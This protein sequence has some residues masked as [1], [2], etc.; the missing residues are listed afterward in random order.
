[1]LEQALA[2]AL[3]PVLDLVLVLVRALA[4]L[5][6]LGRD[7]APDQAQ[8]RVL[9]LAPMLGLGPGQDQVVTKEEEEDRAPDRVKVVEKVQALDLVQGMVRV[10]G[11]GQAVAVDMQNKEIPCSN[12][13]KEQN[14]YD[15]GS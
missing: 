14:I 10:E 2:L 9:M 13:I 1:M 12:N 8:R 15:L 3:A 7:L 5:H 6:P 4:H 11:T